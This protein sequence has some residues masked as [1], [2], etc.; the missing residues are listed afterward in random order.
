MSLVLTIDL[1]DYCIFHF[2]IQDPTSRHEEIEM[3]F[4]RILQMIQGPVLFL[5]LFFSFFLTFFS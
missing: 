3:T 5:S 4:A 1:S 2:D